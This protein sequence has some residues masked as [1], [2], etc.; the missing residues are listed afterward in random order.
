MSN[1]Q[2]GQR[3]RSKKDNTPKQI[4]PAVTQYRTI[5]SQPQTFFNGKIALNTKRAFPTRNLQRA[6]TN[7]LLKKKNL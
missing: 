5:S 2:K 4:L 1:L 3:Y 6:T 7:F